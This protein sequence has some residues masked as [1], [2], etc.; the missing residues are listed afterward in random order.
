[1]A[2][3]TLLVALGPF[4]DKNAPIFFLCVA[5]HGLG[6]SGEAAACGLDVYSYLQHGVNISNFEGAHARPFFPETTVK[7]LATWPTNS[8]EEARHGDVGP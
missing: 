2:L 7:T 3:G 8:Y 1:M 6:L 4:M 5:A